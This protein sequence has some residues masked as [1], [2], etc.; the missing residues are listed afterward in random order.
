MISD[1]FWGKELPRISLFNDKWELKDEWRFAKT[2]NFRMEL[3]CTRDFTEKEMETGH[4]RQRVRGF[5]LFADFN[6]QNIENR[7]LIKFLRQMWSAEHIILTPHYGTMENPN[8]GGYDFEVMLNSDFNPQYFDGRFIGHVIEWSFK[9][10]ELLNKIP[11]DVCTIRLIKATTYRSDGVNYADPLTSL[12]YPNEKMLYG[13]WETTED[14]LS[15]IAYV[16][17][18]T[19]G[20][21][22]PYGVW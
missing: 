9:S 12:T 6:V 14:E 20:E 5:R 7:D 11:E 19:E 8:H 1:V 17:K 22:D 13:G 21:E 2:D 4:V 16:E 18:D 15:E 10:L 3:G